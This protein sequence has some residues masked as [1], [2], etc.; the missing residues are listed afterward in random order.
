MFIMS[1]VFG[2]Y[3]SL[4]TVH[5]AGSSTS[6]HC[7]KT[8]IRWQKLQK[9]W[10]FP[11]DDNNI[12]RPGPH[13]LISA[14]EYTESLDNIVLQFKE[15][16]L[17]DWKDALL[18]A[19]NSLEMQDDGPIWADAPHRCQGSH[20]NDQRHKVPDIE[21]E[22]GVWPGSRNWPRWGD[23]NRSWDGF[24]THPGQHSMRE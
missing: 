21:A 23:I 14:D 24:E 8:T 6:Q 20:V 13:N 3:T 17:E 2:L 11:D 1:L 16:V 15:S 4:C 5:Q 7:Y 19:V 12:H 9:S 10:L 18:S 22:H